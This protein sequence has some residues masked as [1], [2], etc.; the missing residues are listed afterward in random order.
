MMTT[1]P[2]LVPD[3]F[4]AQRLHFVLCD[5]GQ[6]GV[7][8]VETLPE[9]ADEATIVTN[10]L[11]GHY[12]QPMQVIA[13]DLTAGTARDVSAEIAHKVEAAATAAD[14][15]LTIGVQA[16]VEA[17]RSVAVE[18]RLPNAPSAATVFDTTMNANARWRASSPCENPIA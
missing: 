7:A 18:G 12:D 13:V 1:A 3:P 17:Q 14:R 15:D 10:M 5:F 2:T 6:A 9:A 16:F 8:F 11:S 4:T